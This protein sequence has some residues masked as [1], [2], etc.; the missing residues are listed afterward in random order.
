MKKGTLICEW[1][2]YN[3]LIISEVAGT[4]SFDNVI[5]GITFREESDEQTGFKAV[6]YTHLRAHET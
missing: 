3:A 4:V 5:E 6:S 1:D 2:P